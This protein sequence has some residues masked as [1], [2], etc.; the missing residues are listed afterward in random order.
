[1]IF[2]RLCHSTKL[3]VDVFHIDTQ[4]FH[5]ILFRIPKVIFRPTFLTEGNLRIFFNLNILL[6]TENTKGTKKA[7]D[8]HVNYFPA[9]SEIASLSWGMGGWEVGIGPLSAAM[10][11]SLSSSG[12]R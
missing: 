11:E 7:S 9:V 4:F 6:N 1:M 5:T 2:Q 3:C 12:N 8:L 10:H